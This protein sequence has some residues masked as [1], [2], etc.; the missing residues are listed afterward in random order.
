MVNSMAE[1]NNLS[2]D[3]VK[4]IFKIKNNELEVL[5]DID[6]EIREGE[7]I[8]IVGT[9]GCGKSTLARMI[10]GLEKP[11][12]GEIRIAGRRIEKPSVNVGMIF[13]ESRLFPWLTVEDNI[14]FGIHEKMPKEERQKL[15]KKHIEL[16]GL[17]S[18]EK[19]LPKQ[20][21][22]GMQQR[23]SIARALINN[24]AVLLL[25]EPF[26][27]LDALTRINMQNEVLKIWEQ[28]KTTMILITHDI[29]EA[30][31]LSD[32]IFV[33][34]KN[35]GEIKKIIKVEMARPRG[36]NSYDFVKIRKEIYKEFFEDADIELE[37]Y[38]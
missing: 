31:F 18:F 23:V 34:G 25:D 22:G 27:A 36:R 16:V 30:I 38:L 10:A 35:P 37:Y 12:A 8:S 21:S 26:G 33:M 7:F 5:S 4:K 32:R 15:I 9:S 28:E 3:H 17:N 1:I 29:D 19:A 6:V 13:Q 14:N 24:P 20:L 11:T 2:I